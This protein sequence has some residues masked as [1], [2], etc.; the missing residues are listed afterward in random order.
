MASIATGII[1]GADSELVGNFERTDSFSIEMWFYQTT[2][3]TATLMG[4]MIDAPTRRGWEVNVWSGRNIGMLLCHD[5]STG[6]FLNVRTG[7]GQ[8]PMNTWNHVV[9]TY[10][11]GSALSGIKC[12]INGAV[13]TLSQ[14]GSYAVS[15][16]IKNN[17]KFWIGHNNTYPFFPG[18]VDEAVVYDR[19]LSASEITQRYNSGNGT[20]TL[21]NPA[22]LHYHFNEID[23]DAVVDSTTFHRNGKLING[24]G[25]IAG[26]LNDCV[27]LNGSSQYI[28]A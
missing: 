28:E 9:F 25:R 4:H 1:T 18:R 27:S 2:A 20:E 14:I 5:E 24:P 10:N 11:G 16:T 19:V 17:A 8:Y 13:K 12:Y 15:G 7:L 21:I 23:G 3:K 6:N 22:Y 26:K